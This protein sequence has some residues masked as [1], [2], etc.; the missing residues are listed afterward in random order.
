MSI[1]LDKQTNKVF[2]KST[3]SQ[4]DYPA[5]VTSI[6]INHCNFVKESIFIYLSIKYSQPSAIFLPTYRR[7]WSLRTR[8]TKNRL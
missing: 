5:I 3:Q 7:L 8:S 1:A 6:L 2:N 4:E